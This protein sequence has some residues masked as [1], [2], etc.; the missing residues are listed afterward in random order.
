MAYGQVE[1]SSGDRRRVQRRIQIRR[2]GR[3]RRADGL[4]GGETNQ[5][6][7]GSGTDRR[8]TADRRARLDRRSGTDRRDGGRG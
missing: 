3:D 4:V 7:R 8:E 1:R 2:T 5:E 6:R